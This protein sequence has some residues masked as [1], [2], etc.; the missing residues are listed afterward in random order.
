MTTT[1]KKRNKQY[2]VQSVIKFYNRYKDSKKRRP[3]KDWQ[4]I[5]ADSYGVVYASSF[6]VYSLFKK[7]GLTHLLMTKG[8]YRRHG[9][10]H[11]V[12]MS[13]RAYDALKTLANFKDLSLRDALDQA[14]MQVYDG[15]TADQIKQGAISSAQR[16]LSKAA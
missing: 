7:F 12:S 11:K 10:N 14:V 5:L 9:S 16:A 15:L 6:N 1:V 3:A 4:R 13:P 8:G 2:D